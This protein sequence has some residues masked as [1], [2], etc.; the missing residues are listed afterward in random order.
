ME[1][2]TAKQKN[3]LIRQFLLFNIIWLILLFILPRAFFVVIFS[4]I[5]TP[6]EILSA[7]I[8][9]WF[10]T[11]YL[12]NRRS[13]NTN[14]EHQ[15]LVNLKIKEFSLLDIN[16][17][18]ITSQFILIIFVALY[19]RL[20]NMPFIL[21]L[22]AIILLAAMGIIFELEYEKNKKIITSRNK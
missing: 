15:L 11:K 4:V 22:I 10:I 3:N 17:G 20:E 1:I 7:V 19:T 5:I 12:N 18:I 13:K 21:R 6:P 2:N 14:L 9:A 8:L 16:A